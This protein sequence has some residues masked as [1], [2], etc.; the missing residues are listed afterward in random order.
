MAPQY[1]GGPALFRLVG[2]KANPASVFWPVTCRLWPQNYLFRRSMLF[3]S[4]A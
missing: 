1:S 2:P 3:G 4:V